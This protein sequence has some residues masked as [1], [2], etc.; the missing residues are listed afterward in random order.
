MDFIL[1]DW[2]FDDADSLVFYADNP[3]IAVNLR[4]F[5]PSPY[6]AAAAHDFITSCRRNDP[7]VTRILA[8]DVGGMAVGSI[9]VLKK[10]DVYRKSAELGYWL[11]EPFWGQGI[12]TRAVCELCQ[13]AFENMDIIRIFAEPFAWNTGSRRVLEK[14]GF[15]L[16]G[17]LK[18]SVYKNGRLG[19]SC[20]YARIRE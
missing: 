8:I 16:E 3:R 17:I 13:T 15:A 9:G 10:D 7:A 14:A 5:F 11:G 20:V 19:D 12:M 6:T 2:R 4:D 18:N 1:R